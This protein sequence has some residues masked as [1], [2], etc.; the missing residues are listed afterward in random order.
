MGESLALSDECL[1]SL[2]ACGLFKGLSKHVM[3]PLIDNCSFE[4]VARAKEDI[5]IEGN[6]DRDMFVLV[7]GFALIHKQ[8]KGGKRIIL[9][10]CGASDAVGYHAL[11][12][13]TN[14][15]ASV[16]ALTDVRCVGECASIL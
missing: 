12:G 9:D 3:S 11:S 4:E 7:T 14:R 5:I 15:I 6:N 2:Q 10:V 16:T 8:E 13:D 1:L